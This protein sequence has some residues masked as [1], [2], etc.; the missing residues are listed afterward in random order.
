MESHDETKR[1]D[2]QRNFLSLGDDL[3]IY[4]LS[5]WLDVRSLVGLD[6]AITNHV[7]RLLWKKY[8]S[9]IN[10]RVFDDWLYCHQS[11]RWLISRTVRVSNFFINCKAKPHIN[12]ATFEGI[13]TPFL[14]K[15]CH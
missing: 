13:N 5:N 12:D 4:F 1:R 6:L 11:I 14:Q 3:L 9:G 10:A 2:S 15:L 7:E 8:L